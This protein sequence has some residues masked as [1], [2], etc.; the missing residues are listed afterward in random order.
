[1]RLPTDTSGEKLISLLRRYGYAETR[2]TGS[3]IRLTTAL[4]GEHHVT[5]PRHKQLRIGTLHSVLK[6]I[7]NHLNMELDAFVEE[8]LEK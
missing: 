4:N 8:L 2:Q 7:A 5:I 1:M 3:H 6:D